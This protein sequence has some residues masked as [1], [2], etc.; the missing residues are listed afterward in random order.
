MYMEAL[1]IFILVAIVLLLPYLRE[2]FFAIHSTDEIT[3]KERLPFFDMLRGLAILAVILIHTRRFFEMYAPANDL[4][5]LFTAN[6]L[7]RFAIPFFLICSGVLLNP[8]AIT[9]KN[10]T[11]FYLKKVLRIFVPYTIVTLAIAL[12]AKRIDLFPRLLVTGEASVPFYFMVVLF[13]C[14]LVYPL[15]Q[16]I[17]N[18]KVLLW[19]SFFVSLA[20]LFYQDSW[21][22]GDIPMVT[23]F[24]FFFVYGYTKRRD[25]I[26]FKTR[27]KEMHAWLA[28]VCIYL[29]L[30][31]SLPTLLYNVRMI[32]G[33]ALFNLLFFA[34]PYLMSRKIL[35]RAL[36][37]IGT[38]S[39]WIYLLH[40]PIT[41]WAYRATQTLELNYYL[42]FFVSMC[43]ASV[44]SI[45]VAYAADSLYKVFV[46]H[47]FKTPLRSH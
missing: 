18:K 47:V 5:F 44:L 43:A 35:V 46:R 3:V 14:Y 33:I 21:Y 7:T 26:E 36:S 10:I 12:I 40:Y 16:H 42:S 17:K 2:T 22:F 29:V 9:R 13:Q 24:L 38:L 8:F 30:I 15:L 41:L 23:K 27:T 11:D 6:N 4:V 25:F 39:L 28:M 20:S 31:L 19:G 37:W 1:I 32:Y 34:Q 45:A